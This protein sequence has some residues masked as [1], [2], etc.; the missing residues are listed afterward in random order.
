LWN[1]EVCTFS[2][3]RWKIGSL[4]VSLEE[5]R[6][7]LLE[8]DPKSSIEAALFR[9]TQNPFPKDDIRAMRS[10]LGRPDIGPLLFLRLNAYVEKNKGLQEIPKRVPEKVIRLLS[11]RFD[12]DDATESQ[13]Q[14][15]ELLAEWER[16]ESEARQFRLS[17]ESEEMLHAS[18][19]PL[20]LGFW[21]RIGGRGEMLRAQG[22]ESGPGSQF[23]VHD[24]KGDRQWH[25]RRQYLIEWLGY[26]EE[27]WVFEEDVCPR[28]IEA[29]EAVMKPSRPLISR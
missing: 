29:Y 23:L 7:N 9:T 1:G 28:L 15:V 21:K 19:K 13:L 6:E 24:I 22:A 18:Y 16:E 14:R 8:S 11:W 4:E 25:G 5:F 3:N 27:T 17:W 10:F 12:E 2:G 20:L 26:E